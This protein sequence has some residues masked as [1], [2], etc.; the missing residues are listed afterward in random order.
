[1]TVEDFGVS[2]GIP[3]STKL[4]DEFTQYCANHPEERFF[5]ALRNWM[6]TGY[7]LIAEGTDKN[8]NYTEIKDTYYWNELPCQKTTA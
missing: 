6:E 8:D 7:L 1:M 3:R 5:Q 4:L 2:I